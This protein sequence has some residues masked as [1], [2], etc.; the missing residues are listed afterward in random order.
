[1][2]KKNLAVYI[3]II[4]IIIIIFIFLFLI[5]F[6]IAQRQKEQKLKHTFSNGVTVE[7][8]V[9]DDPRSLISETDWQR[10]VAV[11]A[12]GQVYF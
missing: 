2:I 4:I 8:L 5:L 11:F 1:M 3:I 12:I 6:N 10:I 9:I 7:F